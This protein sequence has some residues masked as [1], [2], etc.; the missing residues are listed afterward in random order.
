M[1]SYLPKLVCI[2][3]IYKIRLKKH[4]KE[5]MVYFIITIAISLYTVL[6]K[7]LIGIITNDNYQNGYY[8]QAN[9]I[10][11]IAKTISFTSLNFVM[12]ARI[13]YLFAHNN[14]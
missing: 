1:W 5:S 3:H 4:I 2:V 10:I 8:E 14:I 9:K 12:G 6:D 13:S 11:N 7:V